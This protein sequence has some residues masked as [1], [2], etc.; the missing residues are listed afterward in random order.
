MAT[1]EEEPPL[2]AEVMGKFQ[3][4]FADLLLEVKEGRL[5]QEEGMQAA[6]RR[7]EAYQRSIQ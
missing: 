5:S 4:M 1:R 7:I 3:A 6:T 2:N